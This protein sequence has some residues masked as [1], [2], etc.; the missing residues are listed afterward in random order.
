MFVT[1]VAVLCHLG[2]TDCVEQVVTNSSQDRTLTLQGC[3]IG[4]QAALAKWKEEHPIYRSKAWRIVRYKCVPGI[5]TARA[6]I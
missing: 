1:V 2:S 4:G 6:R 3:A 5:Y